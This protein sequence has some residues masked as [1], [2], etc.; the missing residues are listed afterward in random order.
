MLRFAQHD[1]AKLRVGRIITTPIS[2]RWRSEEL[3]HRLA[4]LL[5]LLDVRDVPA[6]RDLDQD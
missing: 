6:I 3:H 5:G 4:K 2:V 1:T